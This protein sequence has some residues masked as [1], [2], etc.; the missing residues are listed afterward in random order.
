[1]TAAGTTFLDALKTAADTT[2]AA[3]ASFRKES[4]RQLAALEQA[5][6]YA[7]RRLNLMRAVASAIAPAEDEGAAVAGAL[8]TLREKVGWAADSEARAEVLSRFSGVARAIYRALGADEQADAR[9]V[10]TALAEFEDWYAA[11]RQTPFWALFDQY[12]VETP[13][14]DF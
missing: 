9:A 7:F 10:E 3:E 11:S 12:V 1:M 4:A 2:E 6:T 5:R 14:V 8:S 13:R